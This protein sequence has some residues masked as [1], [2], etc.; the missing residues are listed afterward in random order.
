MVKGRKSNNDENIKIRPSLSPHN[1]SLLH[2]AKEH[3]KE[4]EETYPVKN[5][6]H[7]V[8]A[9]V[10]GDIQVKFQ[11]NVGK[12]GMFFGFD[13]VEELSCII[14]NAQCIEQS[15][16]THNEQAA[17]DDDNSDDEMGFHLFP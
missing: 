9:N 14:A 13:T 17:F 4:L 7:F 10:H 2:A 12:K 5:M 8:F 6:P 11:Q 1:K 3:L 16:L 15:R